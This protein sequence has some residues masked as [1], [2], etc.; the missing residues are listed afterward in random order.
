MN[1]IDAFLNKIT[2]YRLMLY[3]LSILYLIAILLSLFRL[4]PYNPFDFIFSGI[5]LLALCYLANQFFSFLFK[6]KPNFESQFI[7]GLILIM[8]I[9]PMSLFQNLLFLTLIPLL[10][11]GSKYL[12]AFNKQHFFNPAAFA[13]VITAIFLGQGASWWAGSMYLLPFILLGG[14]LIARK[15]SRFNMIFG[16]LLSST[17]FL[18]LFKRIPFEI[19]AVSDYLINPGTLF[20]SFIMLTEPITSPANKKLR[21]AF[22]AAAGLIMVLLQTYL[23]IFYSVEL[24]LLVANLLGRIVHFSK[25]YHLILKE[26]KQIGSG[27]WEFLFSPAQPIAF[28]PGQYLEWSLVHPHADSRGFRRY[29]TIASSPTEQELHIAVKI[30]DKPSTFK[31]ALT[32]LRPGDGLYATNLEG[33]FVLQKNPNTSYVFIAGGIGITPFRSMIKSLLDNKIKAQ[34]TL[35]YIT[36]DSN[37]F[38]FDELFDEAQKQFGLQVVHVVSE[39]P[40]ANW[41]GEVGRLDETMIKKHIPDYL[42]RIFYL[43]GPQPMVMGYKKLVQSMGVKHIKTDYFPGYNDAN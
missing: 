20:F 32:N 28:I 21:L 19:K 5:Y 3:F 41:D 6:V 33:E 27:I 12:I 25:K 7:T 1:F 29:F 4:L 35:F 42:N 31:Q 26:K 37:E 11:M 38:V 40:P 2:M 36:H 24:S 8:I 23:V 18:L 39:N 17:L 15:T 9:G 10:A 14:L 13:V 34:I 16:F 30:P 43:S 22:G